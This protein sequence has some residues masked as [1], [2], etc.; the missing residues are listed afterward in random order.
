ML[1]LATSPALVR[2]RLHLRWAQLATRQV[3]ARVRLRARARARVIGV[4]AWARV[5]VREP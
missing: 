5:R 2:S 3:G 4:R 1:E